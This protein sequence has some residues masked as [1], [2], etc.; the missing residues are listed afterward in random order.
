M[1]QLRDYQRAAVDALY[2]Y[3]RQRPGSPLIVLPTGGGKS[4]VLGTICKELIEGWP[5]MRVLV[6]THVRELILSNYQELMNIWPFAPAGIFSAGVGRRDA[7]AQIVF[8]GV[9]TIANKTEQIGHIDVVLVDEAHLM[10][11]NSETQYGKLIDGL[12]VIN[13]DLKLVGLTATPY[14]L[15]EGLL[16]E[17]DGALFDDICYE[18]PI[19]EM[20]EGG[21]LCRPISKGMATGFDLSGVGKQGGDYKQNALQAAIDRDDI[22]SAVVDEIVAYGTVP[23]AERRAWLA[24][25]SGV[26]HARHMRDEIRSRGFTC[27]TITGNT[28]VAERDRIL[29][30][31][32]AGKIRAL[33]NNSVLTTGTNLPIVDLV[34][35]C[36]PT[37]SAGLYVQMAGRG[38]RLYPGKDNCLFLDFAGVVRKHGPIDAVTPPGMKSGDGEAP[39]KQCPPDGGGCG[40]L[41]HA[42]VQVC[43][44]CGYEFPIDETPK[45]SAQAEDVPML[46][47]DEAST[48]QVE[49][50]TFAYHEG[51]GG[52][53]DSVKVSYWVG[54][55]PINEWLGPAHTGFFKSKSDRWWR[56]HGG[57]A[58]FPK[59]V[60]EFLERQ[61]ELLP[62]AEIK[63]KPNGKYWEV[64]DAIPGAANDNMSVSEQPAAANDNEPSWMAEIADLEDVP[65]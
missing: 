4:L 24:F 29:A 9:Q 59:T 61:N 28:P 63:V 11:R 34:A 6:V 16:T 33:T 44:D 52:K 13:P 23:N 36:R 21:Y 54:V 17:G 62:T 46:S 31:F 56:K 26:D 14:R 49:R 48:R 57:Q 39:V 27:E 25:C 58:P 41:I 2:E 64:V 5:D 22:T 51:K 45:I 38:L 7:K 53:Q 37:L 32:K 15:G 3:W 47:K 19:G 55:S 50:R 8:G 18:K 30:D 35:F 40:S 60:L 1:L 43:P 42:S 10:P 65:F 20:I 12:R